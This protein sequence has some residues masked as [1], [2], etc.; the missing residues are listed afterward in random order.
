MSEPAPECWF[1]EASI[2]YGK[3]VIVTVGHRHG[4]IWSRLYQKPFHTECYSNFFALGRRLGHATEY[5]VRHVQFD[6]WLRGRA[7]VTKP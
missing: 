3:Y 2:D 4:E 7:T 5:R 1:C 6:V